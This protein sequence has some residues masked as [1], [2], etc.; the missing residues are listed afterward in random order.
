[1]K[2]TILFVLFALVA[3]VGVNAQS[4]VKI[5]YTNVDVVMAQ[6][7]DAKTIDQKLSEHNKQLQT[8]LQAKVED[9]KKKVAAF[10][11]QAPQM[12]DAVRAD[13]AK[14]LQNLEASI[15]Q[16]QQNGQISIQ[17]KQAELVQPLLDKVQASIN[18]VAKANGYTYVLSEA[19]GSLPVL[20]YADKQGNITDLVLKDLGVTPKPASK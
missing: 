20:L 19:V 15:Q 11:K 16:F 17:K 4:V 9:Y 5:G 12:I 3:T 7:P 8:Q 14:E 13:K 6:L 2:K 18:K 10:Q 1:M